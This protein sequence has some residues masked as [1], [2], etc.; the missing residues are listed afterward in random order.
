M[1]LSDEYF[2]IFSNYNH[3]IL[4]GQQ[5]YISVVNQ[6]WPQQKNGLQET[7]LH[8]LLQL[9]QVLLVMLNFE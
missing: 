6:F 9:W 4:Q 3:I 5:H 1:Q 7:L 8:D 2:M